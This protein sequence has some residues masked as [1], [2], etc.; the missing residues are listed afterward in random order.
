MKS[1][2]YGSVPSDYL[3]FHS[4]QFDRRFF[5]SSP[6]VSATPKISRRTMDNGR[7]FSSECGPGDGLTI[8]WNS[9]LWIGQN[10]GAG[11]RL[12]L[13]VFPFFP[14]T[15]FLLLFQKQV[16]FVSQAFSLVLPLASFLCQPIS[17]LQFALFLSFF[18]ERV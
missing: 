8:H 5:F 18:F 15:T 14:I 16:P 7:H 10:L 2:L 9:F 13:P 12:S 3:V 1:K 4:K 17:P 6:L 11:L